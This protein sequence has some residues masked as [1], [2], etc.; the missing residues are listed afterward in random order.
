[1]LTRQ[2]IV[3][4]LS[5]LLLLLKF[6]VLAGADVGNCVLITDFFSCDRLEVPQNY[7]PIKTTVYFSI[8]LRNL[9]SD[10]KNTTVNVSVLDGT[11]VP[12]GLD[13]LNTTI[14]HNT[15]EH[16]VMSIFVPKW[17]RVG[18][19]T[20]YATVFV[21]GKLVDGETTQFYIG[22]EDLTPPVINLLSPENVTY[23]LDSVPVVFT[24][25]ERSYWMGYSVNNQENVTL[26]G[27]STLTGLVNGQYNIIVYANDTSGNMGFS[28]VYFT[29]LVIHDV[30]VTDL[31][32]CPLQMYIGQLV[33]ISVSVQNEGTVPETFNVSIHANTTNLKTLTITDL[34]AGD[35]SILPFTWNTTGMTKGNYTMKSVAHP[36]L[37]ETDIA[38]N[39]YVNSIVNIMARPD[40][41]VTS[42]LSSK[43]I[44]GQGYSV[45]I[46][47]AVK[48]QGDRA[49][50]FNVTVQANSTLIRTKTITLTSGDST[51]ITFFWNTTYFIKGNYTI[52]TVAWP[53]PN[54]TDTTDNA[55]VDGW[56]V[57]TIPGDVDGDREVSIYDIVKII[58]IIWSQVGDPNYKPNLDINGDGIINIYDI[59]ICTSHYGQSW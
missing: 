16:Y 43:T 9:D 27:N 57:V 19:A 4:A 40:I 10:P 45:Q 22:P 49:E 29:I 42:A 47:V 30:A 39:T 59:V 31:Q 20:A 3:F 37:G 1:M 54:E 58:G 56:I 6:S 36:I 48:N 24:V 52:V 14:P 21:E 17:A 32:C 7:F 46:D 28:Q 8:S 11:S 44:V 12:I 41:E 35:N 23:R 18:F 15:T 38:D 53:V 55:L 13:Q 26:E 34:S 51:F 33:N 50:T 2:Y 25:D 5:L